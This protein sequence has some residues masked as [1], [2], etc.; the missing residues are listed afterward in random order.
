MEPFSV[1]FIVAG[2]RPT[3]AQS[4]VSIITSFIYALFTT[5]EKEI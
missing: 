2:I 3:N 5:L 4:T 1:A